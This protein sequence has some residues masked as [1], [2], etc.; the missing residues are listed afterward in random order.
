LTNRAVAIGMQHLGFAGDSGFGLSVLS[1]YIPFLKN[2]D[3]KLP[4]PVEVM[5]ELILSQIPVRFHT[6][7]V[8]FDVVVREASLS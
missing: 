6:H 3:M 2:A 5:I 8:L 4:V 1:I 7:E